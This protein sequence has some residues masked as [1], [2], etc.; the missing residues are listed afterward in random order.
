MRELER[1]LAA[2]QATG[3]R[4]W[5]GHALG[6]LAAALA[7]AGRIDEGLDTVAEAL[8]LVGEIGE[9]C[10]AAELHRLQGELLIMRAAGD[11]TSAGVVPARFDKDG[12][13]FVSQAEACFD[14]AL[15]LA[16]EQRAR[17]W[18]LKVATSLG[19]S[20]YRQGKREKARR[21]IKNAYDW[22]AEGLDT[23]DL[24]AARTAL[25]AF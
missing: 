13:A 1:G 25:S 23:A 3:G 7:R 15:A 9:N 6:L 12:L 4:L 14:R 11:S 21:T 19:Y 24:T 2:Y 17:S 10:P 18:E 16:R 5:R 20:L 8:L 22:F